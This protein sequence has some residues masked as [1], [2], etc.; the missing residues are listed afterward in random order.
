VTS[1]RAVNRANVGK[2]NISHHHQ[3]PHDK[4][5]ARFETF[6]SR[7]RPEERKKWIFSSSMSVTL[8]TVTYAYHRVF[9]L[10]VA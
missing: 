10:P 8:L 5:P 6:S 1:F 3:N 2:A 7:G 9:A 4:K